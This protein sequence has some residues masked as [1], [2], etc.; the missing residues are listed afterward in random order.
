MSPTSQVL[1]QAFPPCVGR[2]GQQTKRAL[3]RNL[4]SNT[5]EST[6]RFNLITHVNNMDHMLGFS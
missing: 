2:V 3:R 6:E 5:D 1:Y 4:G